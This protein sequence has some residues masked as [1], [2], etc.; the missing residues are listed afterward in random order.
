[1]AERCQRGAAR[2]RKEAAGFKRGE[3]R[4]PVRTK[5][6]AQHQALLGGGCRR[7]VWR[8]LVPRVAHC[9]TWPFFWPMRAS[10]ANQISSGA[11]SGRP[12]RGAF[13]ARGKFF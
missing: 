3:P 11:V 1:M 2:C 4:T 9:R 12:S 6:S 5:R 13:S 10:S 8:G 7:R